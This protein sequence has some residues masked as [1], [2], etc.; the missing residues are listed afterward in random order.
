MPGIEPVFK[1]KKRAQLRGMLGKLKMAQQE[2]RID[3]VILATLTS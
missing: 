3:D 1:K 2:G